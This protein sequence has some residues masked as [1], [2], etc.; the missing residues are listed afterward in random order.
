MSGG[1]DDTLTAA[2][3]GGEQPLGPGK[4]LGRYAIERVLGQG[5]MGVVYA[6]HDPD[7]DR[8]VALKL[9]RGEGDDFARARLLREARA[10]AKLAHANVITVFEVDTVGDRDFV[11]MELID[12]SSLD[13]WIA[14]RHPVTEVLDVF[15]KAGR[16]LAAAHDKGLVHR[17]F[18]PHNVLIGNDGRVVVTDFGLARAAEAGDE[19][20]PAGD[21]ARTAGDGGQEPGN[22]KQETGD[23]KR[24]S[25]DGKR[26]TGDEQTAAGKVNAKVEL[27]RGDEE[28][29]APVAPTVAPTVTPAAKP[30]WSTTLTQTGALLGTPAYMAPEQWAS[31]TADPKSDQFAFCVSL[32]E[33]VVGQRPFQ[34]KELVELRKA[35]EGGPPPAP[36]GM[37]AWLAP[38]LRR[39][40]AVTSGA[41][42][43]SMKAVID[44]IEH[45][46]GRGRRRLV[47]AGVIAVLV[48]GGAAVALGR[49]GG[50][51]RTVVAGATMAPVDSVCQPVDVAAAE[52][53]SE[54]RRARSG[55]RLAAMPELAGAVDRYFTR[56]TTRWREAYARTCADRDD[57]QRLA[58]LACLESWRDS[59]VA[60]LEGF[61]QL[62]AEVWPHMPYYEIVPALD[63]CLGEAPVQPPP[64]PAPAQRD[65]VRE[66]R[67]S[68]G[69]IATAG[70]ATDPRWSEHR[71]RAEALGYRPAVI[72]IDFIHASLRERAGDLTGAR[73]GFEDVVADAEAVGATALRAD[74]RIGLVSIDLAE[75]QPD[76]VLDVSMRAAR[77]ATLAA[78]APVVRM[79]ALDE[80]E[81]FRAASRDGKPARAIE[82]WTRLL[83]AYAEQGATARA[84]RVTALLAEA[85]VARGGPGDR[86]RA[87][88]LL[89]GEIA[90]QQAELGVAAVHVADLQA[91][92]AEQKLSG[93]P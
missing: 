2:P 22:R 42:W 11:A 5:G 40:L 6:A 28:T 35:I 51:E 86:E 67:T 7:L 82:L 38:I 50:R 89:I 31:A 55:E 56:E 32:W 80:L 3:A 15:I 49:G 39:G 59:N 71:A 17:D 33:A 58:R 23:G 47:A 44:A 4:H 87:R 14:E 41:R 10:M 48:A 16:G 57:R 26:R 74:A 19:A 12:G 36:R 83:P 20:R 27:I 72:E 88:D 65:V 70:D 93:A 81:A 92:L 90:R 69:I 85:L 79:L 77:S 68:T 64:P 66:L 60:W 24:E 1:D 29:L 9:L 76:A 62:P 52:L 78:G 73:R 25:E 54:P 30:S 84:A 75:N 21:G 43:P 45:G 18:K 53:W 61:A 37:P 13:R 8:T 91:V 63:P 46:R 34:G